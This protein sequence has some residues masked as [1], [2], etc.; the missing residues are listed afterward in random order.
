MDYK[1]GVLVVHGMGSQ[2]PDFTN[3]MIEELN[4]RIQDSSSICWQSAHWADVLTKKENDLDYVRIRKF[5]ISAFG[6]AIAYQRVPGNR[7]HVYDEVHRIIH[8]HLRELRDKLRTG[9]N[10]T[11]KD[12]GIR[13][14]F[15]QGVG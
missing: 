6:D 2:G 10:A 11:Q 1:M 9:M 3:P 7:H 4:D 13:Y 14:N 15:S 12:K 5:V 8:Q